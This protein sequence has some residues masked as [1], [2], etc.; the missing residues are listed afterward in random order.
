LLIVGVFAVASAAA[1]A[2]WLAR[3]ILTP[4]GRLEGSIVGL[5]AGARTVAEHLRNAVADERFLLPGGDGT[6]ITM[7]IGVACYPDDTGDPRELVAHAD[8]ALYATNVAGRNR[9]LLYG[10]TLKSRFVA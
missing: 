5:G 2:V 8:Q 10:A 7:C 3:S 4:L 6:L 1:V 9:V